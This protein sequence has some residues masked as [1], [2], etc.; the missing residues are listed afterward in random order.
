V[1]VAQERH[2]PIDLLPDRTADTLAAWLRR[3]DT[4]TTIARDRSTEYARGIAAGAPHVVEI[5]D[6]W[7][8]HK[9]LRDAVERFLNQQR[10]ALQEITLPRRR[11]RGTAPD[12]ASLLA[13]LTRG[14]PPRS[15]T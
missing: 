6:R 11:G 10:Q 8:V 7:A 5:L 15:R 14:P 9:N 3:H 12:S 2:R 1:I 13:P 4:L